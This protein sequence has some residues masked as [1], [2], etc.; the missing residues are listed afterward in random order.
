MNEAITLAGI[1]AGQKVAVGQSGSDYTLRIGSVTKPVVGAVLATAAELVTEAMQLKAD[2]RDAA[3]A[4]ALADATAQLGASLADL[5]I[6]QD[7]FPLEQVIDVKFSP[8]DS[9]LMATVLDPALAL[10]LTA[11][12]GTIVVGGFS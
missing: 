1:F 4:A 12:Q 6:K 3:F 7:M 5:L 9:T 11:F 2:E 8:G 10:L